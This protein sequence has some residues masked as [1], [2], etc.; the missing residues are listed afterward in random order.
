MR[1]RPFLHLYLRLIPEWKQWGNQEPNHP[2]TL[3]LL[4]KAAGFSKSKTSGAM[5]AAGTGEAAGRAMPTLGQRGCGPL[6][7]AQEGWFFRAQKLPLG[8]LESGGRNG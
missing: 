5:M 4:G 7:S 6:G 8:A 1:T 2:R 3:P